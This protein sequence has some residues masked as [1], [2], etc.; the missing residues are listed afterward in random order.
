MGLISEDFLNE[1][2]AGP[3][4]PQD[5]MLEKKEDDDFGFFDYAG[6]LL[7]APLRGLAGAAE[8]IGEIGNILPGVDYDIPTNLGWGESETFVGGAIEGISE[9]AVGF[10]PVVGWV[11]KG[12]KVGKGVKLA[13][14]LEKAAKAKGAKGFMARRGQEAVA[15]GVTDFMVIQSHEARLSDLI[16]QF[17]TL[18]NPITEFLQSDEEDPEIVGR[19]K[20]AVEGIGAGIVFDSLL[21]GVRSLWRGK[22]VFD[23]GIAKGLEPEE[24]AKPAVKEMDRA[25]AETADEVVDTSGKP[26]EVLETPGVEPPET[27]ATRAAGEPDE[28]EGLPE[29]DLKDTLEARE[30]IRE[31][32]VIDVETGKLN[33]RGIEGDLKPTIRAVQEVLDGRLTEAVRTSDDE[34]ILD[35]AETVASFTGESAETITKRLGADRVS[36][37][38]VNKRVLFYKWAVEAQT[39][40]KLKPALDA[41]QKALDEDGAVT[42]EL[43]LKATQTLTETQGIVKELSGLRTAQSQG[44]R[45]FKES[46]PFMALTKDPEVDAAIRQGRKDIIEELGGREAMLKKLKVIRDVLENGGGTGAA[47]KA[48]NKQRNNKWLLAFNEGFINNILSGAKT[49]TT[50]FLGP[51]AVSAYRPLETALGAVATGD[52]KIA[53]RSYNELM[54]LMTGWRDAW[55]MSKMAVL[56][57]ELILDP[58]ARQI[59]I[60]ASQR[61]SISAAGLDI[62]S[63]GVGSMVNGLGATVGLSTRLT[64]GTDE[65]VKQLNY[66]AIVRADLMEQGAERGLKGKELAEWTERSVDSMVINGAALTARN[67]EREANRQGLKGIKKVNWIKSKLADGDIQDRQ[68]LAKRALELARE[69]TF[70]RQLKENE[71]TFRNLSRATQQT[72][73]QNPVLR[74]FIPFVRTPANLLSFAGER[75]ADPTIQ[76][77]RTILDRGRTTPKEYKRLHQNKSRLMADLGSEDPQRKAEAFGRVIAGLGFTATGTMFTATGNLTGGGPKDFKQR[78][79]LEESGWRP[80]SIKVGEEYLSYQRM[81]PF[82]SMLGIFADMGDVFRYAPPEMESEVQDLGYNMA[83]AVARNIGSKTYL[84]GITDIA[85]LLE[86]PERF[87]SK[88]ARGFAGSMIPLSGFLGQSVQAVSGDESMREIRSLTDAMMAKVPFLSDNLDPQRNFMGEPTDRYMALGGRWTDWFLPIV[89]STTSSDPINR[90]IAQIGH[91]F[92]PPESNRYDMNLRD[93]RGSSGQSAYDRWMELHQEVR[94]GGRSLN[95]AL[96]RLIRSSSYRRLSPEGFA[97]EDSPRIIEI[98][99]LVQRYR[100]KAEE[101]LFREFPEVNVARK[102]KMVVRRSLRTGRTKESIRSSLF[103]LD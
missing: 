53:R 103:P 8:G 91:A 54:G 13:G 79:L 22:K 7:V 33:L 61:R 102:N 76:L 27:P 15:G 62:Q 52:M 87:V 66:R 68:A 3:L 85:G 90:E 37:E 95:Q 96:N 75:T 77:L 89:H 34:V 14:G 17:P 55:Q 5:K 50:N 97:G 35:N 20:A 65:F 93:V 46:E 99:Q 74:P 31:E 19:L 67:L 71:S 92:S 10:F 69:V 12:A 18:Q 63:K 49:L 82:A 48:L 98:N 30:G 101:Q 73:N 72:V 21:T 88:T 38:E 9:F 81:D 70:T 83:I 11:G 47:M 78:K 57:D 44:L 40:D 43:L 26:A 42:D 36:T 29:G 84:Q 32:D 45:I 100:T 59:D 60:P 4:R 86:N 39:Q 1:P 24:A 64:G 16:Q 41:V 80:Y 6:D 56:K 51:M 94:V 58:T 28:P 25:T 2:L 23:E